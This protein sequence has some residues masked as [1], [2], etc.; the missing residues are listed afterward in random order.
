MARDRDERSWGASCTDV[1][2][3]EGQNPPRAY[4]LYGLRLRS[5][6]PLPCSVGTE[7]SLAEVELF[8]GAAS[9]FLEAAREAMIGPN[10]PKWFRCACLKDGS[11]L[12]RWSGLFEFLVFPDGRRIAGRPLTDA[13]REAF[14]TYLLGQVLSFALLKQGIE[15][16]H[17]T[18][19]VID[20]GTVGFVGDCGY[21]KSSLGAAFLQAGFPLLTDDQLVVREEGRDFFTY[22]GPPRIKLFPEI[23]RSL[24]GKRDKG[25]PM[26]NLT[27]KLIIPLD[28]HQFYHA[29]AP[30]KA[31]YVLAR[32]QAASRCKQVM[33]R[34]ISQSRAFLEL[35]RNTFNPVIVERERLMRQFSLATLVASKV[36][37]KLLSYP[38]I[39]ASLPSVREAILSDLR[40]R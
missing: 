28:H 25:T 31:L 2:S 11:I 8:E 20:G 14:H 22:P 19:V 36:P 6:W 37:V 27:P 21:G 10:G 4:C 40:H 24:L 26:N 30:L 32:P 18:A 38:R 35:L 13:S 23:A 12:L 3:V 9:L 34:R 17:S 33:I 1:A 16:L 5:Q 29:A 15:P 39:L 7:P